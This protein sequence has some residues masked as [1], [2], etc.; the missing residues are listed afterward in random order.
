MENKVKKRIEWIDT[1]RGLAMFFVIWGHVFPTNKG[2]IRKYIYSFHLPLFFFISGL[3]F[4][5][6]DK[7]PFKDFLKKKFK[8]LI[9]P[10]IVIN[11]VCYI[12]MLILY[13]CNLVNN[14]SYLKDA[15]GILYS[16][17]ST[18]FQPSSPSWF[19]ITLF[20][21]ELL[22]Y[23]LKKKSTNDF[24]LGIAVSIC[25]LIGYANSISKY[26]H[27]VPLHYD[28][29]FMGIVFYYIGYLFMKNIDTIKSFFNTKI[30]MLLYGLSF[31][32]IGMVAQYFNRRVSMHT[33]VY[34]S[35]TLFLIGSVF[36]IVGL[37]LFVN[38]I[39]KKSYLFKNI[40]KN[41]IFYLAYHRLIIDVIQY[42]YP[43]LV[44]SNIKILGIAILITIVLY[45]LS[46][47]T[48]R[49]CPALIGKFN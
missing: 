44:N 26:Q 41:T 10:Y 23:F 6:S 15:L 28:T 45:P 16:N 17:N 34:G 49:F 7:L 33:N 8:G 1:L 25:G 46:L 5:N 29:I 30:K 11:I 38:L 36:T 32:V 21:T 9:I 48:K 2:R 31:G 47:L 43:K 39:L 19:L 20:L 22:F 3:T 12:V 35:I 18:F 40:G 24:N 4:R 13:N 14:F 42:S 37:V 27:F